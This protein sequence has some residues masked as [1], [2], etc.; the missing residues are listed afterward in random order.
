[1]IAREFFWSMRGYTPAQVL[2]TRLPLA[3]R[4]RALPDAGCKSID[5]QSIRTHGTGRARSGVSLGDG[6]TPGEVA[7]NQRLPMNSEEVR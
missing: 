7:I 6:L 5:G 1:M 2:A 4:L 3:T